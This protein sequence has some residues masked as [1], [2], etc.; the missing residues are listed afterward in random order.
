MRLF[1]GDC[2][3]VMEGLEDNS[4]D[5]VLTDPPYGI[6]DCKWD[7][8]ID[9]KRMWKELNRISKVRTPIVLFA[10]QPFTTTLIY[11]NIRRYR[12]QWVW[13]KKKG[14]NFASVKYQ[15]YKITEDILIFSSGNKAV[16]Y[17]PIMT[18]GKMRNKKCYSK[19]ELYG[20]EPSSDNFSDDYYPKNLLTFSNASQK[21]KIHPTQKPVELLEYLIKTYSNEGE[22]VLDFTM[23]SGS[24]GVACQNL[25]R[26][27]IGIELDKGYYGKACER[28]NYKGD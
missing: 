20:I 9:L 27:F 28:L 7:S 25:D 11:S 15:P 26:N 4:I 21:G 13:N 12:H 5:L 19:S 22:T 17:Y 3:A 18:K 2:F 23:G 10:A 14:G 16:N 8:V 1:N 6:T 24:T